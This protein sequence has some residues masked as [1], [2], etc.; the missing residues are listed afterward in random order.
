V[1]RER[2]EDFLENALHRQRFARYIGERCRSSTIKEVA[3]VRIPPKMTGCS[4]GT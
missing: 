4:A 1:K 3:A 2:L